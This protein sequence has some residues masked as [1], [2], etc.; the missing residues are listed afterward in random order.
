MG[1]IMVTIICIQTTIW[2]ME[3]GGRVTCPR[4]RTKD[5]PAWSQGVSRVCLP[6][7]PP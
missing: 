3:P 4:Y 5:K 1:C 2:E 7:P 6:S